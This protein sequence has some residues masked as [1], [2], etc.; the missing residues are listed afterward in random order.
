[1]RITYVIDEHE[2][3]GREIPEI[4]A[5]LGGLFEGAPETISL[6]L[7]GRKVSYEENYFRILQTTSYPQS[8]RTV[9]VLRCTD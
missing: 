6:K 8:D 3:P 9:V 5:Q 7:K 1:M 2:W 4:T